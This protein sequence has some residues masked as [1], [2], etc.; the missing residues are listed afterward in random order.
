VDC[1]K[2]IKTIVEKQQSSVSLRDIK[3]VVRIFKFYYHYLLFRESFTKEN[4]MEDDH[5]MFHE[6][7]DLRENDS[8]SDISNQHFIKAF[9]MTILVN[10][11]FRIAKKGKSLLN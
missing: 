6:F 7:C 10:Y 8:F 9:V 3:R 5:D 1:Q 4:H 2:E 11:V